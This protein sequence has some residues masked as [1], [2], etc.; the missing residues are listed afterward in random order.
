MA[1][2][3]PPEPI[4]IASPSLDE[5]TYHQGSSQ[6]QSAKA[7]YHESI[8][9]NL[10]LL[11]EGVQVPMP[12]TSSQPPHEPSP[13]LTSRPSPAEDIDRDNPAT[14][15]GSTGMDQTTLPRGGF[16]QREEMA[17]MGFGCRS[18]N[19]GRSTRGSAY[20][21]CNPPC[22]GAH[23]SEVQGALAT[24]TRIRRRTNALRAC[25]EKEAVGQGHV[26]WGEGGLG[27]GVESSYNGASQWKDYENTEEEFKDR[28]KGNSD[29]W[30]IHSTS[31]EQRNKQWED[32]KP[33]DSASTCT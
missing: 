19:T 31:I 30:G 32:W 7:I 10:S 24:A 12:E 3:P 5:P 4:L 8:W 20:C 15:S 26:S 1:S 29:T 33:P 17:E 13:G 6:E 25:D 22:N 18:V 28:F 14:D 9:P 16:P 2:V 27:G 21:G 23:V 11:L